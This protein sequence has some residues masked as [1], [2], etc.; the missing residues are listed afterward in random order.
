MNIGTLLLIIFIYIIL[1]IFS[2]YFDDYRTKIAYWFIVGLGTLT[3]MNI[4]LT[5]NYYISLRNEVGIPGPRGPRGDKGPKG[6]IGKCTLSESCNIQNCDDKIY[7][8]VSNIFPDLTRGCISD[9]KS[10]KDVATKE[11]AIP[12]NKVVN[13]LLN[14]CQST[15]MPEAEFMRRIRPQL[16]SM[17]STGN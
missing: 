6:D 13:Q 9:P 17:N 12:I 2:L 7:N 1:I 15:K 11:K 8:I 5:I 3:I 4:Y 14:E 16:N 10:C